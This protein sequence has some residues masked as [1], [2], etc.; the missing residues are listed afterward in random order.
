MKLLTT[1]KDFFKSLLPKKRQY[2]AFDEQTEKTI[3]QIS[4]EMKELE[5][6]IKK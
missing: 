4:K 2:S 1:I 5:K 6:R 3:K